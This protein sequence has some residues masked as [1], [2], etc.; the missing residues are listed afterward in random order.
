MFGGCVPFL[1]S[2]RRV[3]EV[4]NRA[5]SSNLA[6]VA[7]RHCEPSHKALLE[8]RM[9]ACPPAS[10]FERASPDEN[11]VIETNKPESVLP[12]VRTST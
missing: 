8:V 10:L 9:T 11:P 7:V 2:S 3:F 1:S 5:E 4:K 12:D 6:W